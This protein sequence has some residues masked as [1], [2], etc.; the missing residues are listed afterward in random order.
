[1]NVPVFA[2][3]AGPTVTVPTVTGVNEGQTISVG[4]NTGGAANHMR[5]VLIDGTSIGDLVAT[6]PGMDDVPDLVVSAAITDPSGQ[7]TSLIHNAVE[8]G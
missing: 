2:K 8:F 1:M 5:S 7:T 4:P 6:D 3:N